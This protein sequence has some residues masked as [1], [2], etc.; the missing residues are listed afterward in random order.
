MA[1]VCLLYACGGKIE[2][3]NPTVANTGD[4]GDPTQSSVGD[5]TSSTVTFQIVPAAD[6][7]LGSPGISGKCDPPAIRDES[8]F[9]ELARR[10]SE[11]EAT[12]CGNP[13]PLP[14]FEVLGDN[15]QLA[16]EGFTLTWTGAHYVND[17]CGAS[18][19]ECAHTQ[20]TAYG[21]YTIDVCGFRNPNP[22]WSDGCREAS[23][24]TP[25]TIVSTTFDYP[26]SAPVL[27]TMFD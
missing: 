14:P 6:W 24:Q 27:V 20:C 21:L 3:N 7:C 18:A 5:C 11:C 12:V 10:V 1:L 23:D 25:V 2:T 9:L 19:H 16:T 8:G 26:A 22:E 17:T 15:T 13:V 4:M